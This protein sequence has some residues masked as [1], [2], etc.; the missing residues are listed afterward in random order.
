M[1][2][3]LRGVRA[4]AARPLLAALVSILCPLASA[5]AQAAGSNAVASLQDVRVTDSLAS[6]AA[7]DVAKR[8]TS[9]TDGAASPSASRAADSQAEEDEFIAPSRPSVA[10]PAEFQRAGVLQVEYG[11]SGNFRSPSLSADQAAPLALRFAASNRLLLEF[12]LDTFKSETDRES[13]E[14][15]TGIGDA[16][17]GFQVVALKD[18]DE[19]PTLAFYVKLPT[20]SEAKSLGTGRFDHTLL[21]LLS[22]KI[23]KTDIDFNVGFLADGE[24]DGSGWDHGGMAA[25]DVSRDSENNFGVEAE[26]SGTSIDS[27]L[28]RGFYALGS[29]NYKVNRRLRFDR[30][31][32]FGLNPDAPRFGVFA[33]LSLGVADL[34]KPSR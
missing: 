19:H 14:R 27:Q 5:R 7:R 8:A 24:A 26:L 3:T 21:L 15:Q 32:R 30:G 13:R 20:A 22:K 34:Y 9:A 18:T 11:Y 29:V 33:G 25:F 6:F 12:D 31:A 2:R 4:R 1:N 17:L 10:N 16:R 28:P 23:G